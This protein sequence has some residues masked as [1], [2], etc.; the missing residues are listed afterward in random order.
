MGVLKNVLRLTADPYLRSLSFSPWIASMSICE[1]EAKLGSH[2]FFQERR[3]DRRAPEVGPAREH[4][5][6]IRNDA[7][8]R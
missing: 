2:C 7:S 4:V 5:K 1:A 6:R 8:D 3:A